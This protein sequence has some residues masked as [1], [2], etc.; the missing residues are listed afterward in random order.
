MKLLFDHQLS[1]KLVKRL[2]DLYPDSAHVHQIGLDQVADPVIWEHARANDF[3]IVTKD[4]DFTDLSVLRGFPP[5]VIWLKL[6][7]CTTRQVEDAIR[8]H[9]NAI[10]EFATDPIN[11]LLEIRQ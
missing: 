3:V 7:N 9:T 10:A 6:G 8:R 5:K 11:G 2:S 4:A 1:P